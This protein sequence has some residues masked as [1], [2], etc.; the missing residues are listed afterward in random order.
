MSST[1]SIERVAWQAYA[2]AC[3]EHDGRHARRAAAELRQLP[4]QGAFPT[5]KGGRRL[6][7]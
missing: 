6:A 7:G 4:R 5:H 3:L 1:D 2:D